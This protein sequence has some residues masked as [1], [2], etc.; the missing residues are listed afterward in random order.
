VITLTI[1]SLDSVF[2]TFLS[3]LAAGGSALTGWLRLPLDDVESL[4]GSGV[5]AFAFGGVGILL[6]L[7]TGL[8][9]TL[10][11]AFF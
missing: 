11:V 6:A 7:D 8:T 9:S 10:L 3:S 2:F 1:S 5:F 4:R